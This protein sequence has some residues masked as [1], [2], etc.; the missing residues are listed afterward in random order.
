MA[1]LYPST[2]GLSINSDAFRI[3]ADAFR[4]LPPKMQDQVVGRAMG[5]SKSV[6]ERTYAQLASARM[7]IAQKHIKARTR[8]RITGGEMVMTIRSTQIPLQELNPRQTRKGVSVPLRGSYRSA[9]IAKA[10]KGA[11]KVLKRKGSA[12]YPTRML[13]GPN[14]AGEATRN[15]PVYEAMLGEIAE[16]VF[17]TEMARGISYMLGRL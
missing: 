5:R 8:T 1:A 3:L 4:Q 9:F 12:R 13:F 11:G 6:V 15:P 14:P 17:M 10:G 16:G 7:D 2:A